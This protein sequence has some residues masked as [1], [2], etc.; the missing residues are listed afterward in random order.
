VGVR[1]DDEVWRS[2]EAFNSFKG[3]CANLTALR[4]FREGIA[5][6]PNLLAIGTAV[7]FR[8]LKR[9][10]ELVAPEH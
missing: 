1:H 2:W 4:L 5:T 10:S 3:A 7:H 6:T 8:F 9:L